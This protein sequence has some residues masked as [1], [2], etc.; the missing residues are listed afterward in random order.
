MGLSKQLFMDNN[1]PNNWNEDEQHF[2]FACRITTS[3]EQVRKRRELEQQQRIKQLEEDRRLEAWGRK[4]D[5]IF[6]TD[7]KKYFK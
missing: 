6:G 5:A 4:Q 1:L 7:N 2:G 3:I